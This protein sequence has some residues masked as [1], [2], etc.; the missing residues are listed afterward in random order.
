MELTKITMELLAQ[1]WTKDQTPEGFTPWDDFYGG[2]EYKRS[3]YHKFV[4]QTPCGLLVMG[5]K[6]ISNMAYKG[7]HWM[8]EN[9]NPVINC[10]F[11]G[12]GFCPIRHPL[13][14]EQYLYN[15][16]SRCG[17][18]KHC[19]VHRT[20]LPWVY[21]N[22]VE[23]VLDDNEQEENALWAV[24][25]ARHKGRACRHQAHYDRSRKK[26][27]HHYNPADCPQYCCSYCTI[28]DKPVSLKKANVYY[29]LKRSWV[30]RGEGFL[31]DEQKVSITKGIK[32][33]R[34]SETICEAIVKYGRREVQ[35]REYFANHTFCFFGG[36]V[37]VQNLRW[38]RRESRD[39][40][41]DLQDVANGI[42]VRHKSDSEKAAKEAKRIR[43][44]Q[45]QM[46]R[47]ER[48]KRMIR[49]FGIDGLNAAD[50]NRA[51]KHLSPAQILE[52]EREYQQSL[53]PKPKNDQECFFQTVGVP[54]DTQFT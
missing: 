9:D 29:D 22:S 20:D 6:V 10:P 41:Q 28:L 23:K 17:N 45:A 4:F 27:V 3:V 52:A 12:L 53:L 39:L 30:Q 33:M 5:S 14:Q 26:W 7:V 46:R 49:T 1:G 2:W 51:K 34:A 8:V 43:R 36:S 18:Y 32:F 35:S 50:R 21:E 13:L 11:W 19:S 16:I 38:D 31:P 24:T 44:A 25:L 54:D 42:E 37:E 15:Y 48:F 47:V 40:L